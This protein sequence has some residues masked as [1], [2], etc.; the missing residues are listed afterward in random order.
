MAAPSCCC[1]DVPLP[2]VA[3]HANCGENDGDV[4]NTESQ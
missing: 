1:T 3:Y 4:E 2:A